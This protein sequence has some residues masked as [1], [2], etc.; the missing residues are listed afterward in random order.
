MED[1][2]SDRDDASQLAEISRELPP[3]DLDEPSA[4]RIAHQARQAVGRREPLT[5]LVE[6]MLVV[7]FEL[8]LIGCTVVKLVELLR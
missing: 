1:G 4:L 2:M 7:A 5:R 6:P 3:V 8:S